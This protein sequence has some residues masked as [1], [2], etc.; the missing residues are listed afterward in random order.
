MPSSPIT[1]DSAALMLWR[2]RGWSLRARMALRR[3]ATTA[4]G[5]LWRVR[6]VKLLGQEMERLGRPLDD[7]EK[8][9]LKIL[10]GKPVGSQFE[11]MLAA[12]TMNF[13]EKAKKEETSGQ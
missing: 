8:D 3:R 13:A 11:K 5:V 1:V 12:C 6:Y 7:H 4:R 9:A 10:V 2:L